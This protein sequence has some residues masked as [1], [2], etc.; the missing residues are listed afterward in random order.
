MQFSSLFFYFSPL[1]NRVAVVSGCKIIEGTTTRI[2]SNYVILELTHNE[3]LSICG[4]LSDVASKIC[5]QFLH[6]SII[7]IF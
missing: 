1:I 5:N 4:S 2:V 3:F 6:V 7:A